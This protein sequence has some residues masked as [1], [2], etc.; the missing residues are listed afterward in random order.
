MLHSFA[1]VSDGS[2]GVTLDL[3]NSPRLWAQTLLLIPSA[4]PG[5]PITWKTQ[6]LPFTDDQDLPTADEPAVPGPT[7]VPTPHSSCTRLWSLPSTETC[8]SSALG[9]R[10][11]P[12]WCWSLTGPGL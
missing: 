8:R 7:A 3:P 11:A 4:S 1:V 9:E 2:K 5:K 12:N 6:L 10:R